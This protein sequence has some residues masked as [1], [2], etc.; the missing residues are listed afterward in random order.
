MNRRT[1]IVSSAA[2]GAAGACAW[3]LWP[4]QGFT[5]PCRAALPAALASH[6]LVQ[7][8]WE[9][10]DPQRLWDCHVHLLGTGDSG[11]GIWI[12]PQ[13]HNPAYPAQYAR[14]LFF[15]NAACADSGQGR[16]DRSY[17]ERMQALVDGMRPGVKLMLLAFDLG[18]APTGDVDS[19]GSAFH[20]PNA[21]AHR[22]ARDHPRHF[23]WVASIHPY[24]P[25]CV[26]ALEWAAANGARAVKWLPAAMGIDP[27]SKRCDRFYEAAARLAL[28][29]ITHAGKERAVKGADRPAF[30]NPLRLRR[31]LAHGVRVVV[32]HCASMGEDQDI[33][34]GLDGPSIDS[35]ELFAR[36]M[37]EP[38]HERLLFGDVSA[39]PQTNRAGPALR[40]VIER[41]DWHSR[42]LNGSDYP[43]PGIMPLYS[44]NALA[45]MGFIDAS[46]APILQAIR[47]HNPLLFDFVLKRHLRAGR[48][49]LGAAVFHT[50]NFFAQESRT[51]T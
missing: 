36:L 38:R 9:G 2:A 8:A 48:Q 33:D 51:E 13:M 5:N 37:D 3:T 46:S 32:A 23:E 12:N 35:F 45:A 17:V 41:T 47:E 14:R 7:A 19:A 16:G 25:D 18:H 27:A 4:E 28:P 10:V 44:M 29:L 49:R 21:Y 50:R 22:I 15:L 6:E 42:L 34:R 1:F 26:E 31:A 11:S 39:M 43:L 40:R 30:G 24:R 20:T